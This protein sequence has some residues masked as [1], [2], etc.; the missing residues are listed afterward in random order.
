M[1]TGCCGPKGLFLRTQHFQQ[2]DRFFEATVRGALQ[3]GQLHTFGFQQLTLDQ[4]L[5]DAG[6]ISVLS[7]RGIFP[8]R[9]T[10]RHPRHDGR[11]AAVTGDAGHGRGTGAGRLA[12]GTSRRRRLRS[13][14]AGRLGARYHGRIV[15]V[16]D[17]VQ[18]GSDP[19]EIE[20]PGR[21]RC[22]RARQIGRWLHRA[23]DSRNQGRSS[24]R[25]RLAGRDVPAAD[26]VTGAVA[27]YRQLL[28]EVVTGLDQIAE[29]HGKMV[30]GGQGAASKTC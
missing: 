5:L 11:A 28:L 30:M 29:A 12:A 1:Q 27:W 14:H 16:R 22:A 13:A 26:L 9:N 23:A 6:Q 17:A 8:G 3:A 25:R 24:R 2:Q 20:M 15:S 18:G 10:F 4:A 21:K 19:E 7:A